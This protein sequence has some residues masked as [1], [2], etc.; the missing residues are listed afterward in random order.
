MISNSV[1]SLSNCLSANISNMCLEYW[2]FLMTLKSRSYNS[3][4]LQ[5]QKEDPVTLSKPEGY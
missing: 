4:M 1:Y 5:L 3:D 2:N